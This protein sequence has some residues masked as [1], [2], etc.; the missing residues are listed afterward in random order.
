MLKLP[1][2][3]GLAFVPSKNWKINGL[4]IQHQ[5]ELLNKVKNSFIHYPYIAHIKVIPSIYLKGGKGFST[6]E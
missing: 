6:L 3:V 1:I 4:H 2:K 5:I